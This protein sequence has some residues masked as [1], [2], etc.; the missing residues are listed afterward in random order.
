MKLRR[1]A[2]GPDPVKEGILHG[3]TTE[4]EVVRDTYDGSVINII[5]WSMAIVE[6][7]FNL[8]T[9]P[10]GEVLMGPFDET[11]ESG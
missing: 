1:C 11:E 3:F 8:R 7:D 10:V 6:V 4:L 5:S 2:I 9:V